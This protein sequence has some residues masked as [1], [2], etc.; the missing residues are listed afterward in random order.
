M[1]KI[2]L[3]SLL[4]FLLLFFCPIYSQDNSAEKEV[5]K[6]HLNQAVVDFSDANYDKALESS[7]QALVN[8]FAINDD[9]LISQSYNTIGAIFNECSETS[10]AIEFYNKAL[11]YAKKLNNDKMFNW[12]YSNLGSVYYFNDIDVPK[13]ISYYKKSLFYAVKIKDTAQIEYTKLNLASAYFAINKYDLGNQQ[14]N[15]IKEQILKN[16][17]QEAK[18][19]LHLLLGI[20]DSNNN[21]KA[22]GE[23][24]FFIAKTIAEQN[25]LD[26]FLINVYENLVKHYKK[27]QEI[28]NAQLYQ[29]KLDSLNKIVYSEDKIDNLKKAATQIELQEYKIQLGKVEKENEAQQK[30]LKDSKLIVILFIV[31]LIILLLLLLTLYKNIK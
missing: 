29:E 7:K 24:H 27:H 16:D 2:K 18:M 21:Q 15:D 3:N 6:K 10:K 9:L 11:V 12:I 23:E 30:T 28:E 25:G 1:N 5:I 17:N 31:I 20:Y 8:A 13:G 14:I 26:S 19:S 4:L 22:K